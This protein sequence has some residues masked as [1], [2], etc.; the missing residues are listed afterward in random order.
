MSAENYYRQ[1]RHQKKMMMMLYFS[2]LSFTLLFFTL[3]G[4]HHRW[5]STGYE[6]PSCILLSVCSRSA[7]GLITFFLQFA[8]VLL[9]FFLHFASAFPSHRMYH[10]MMQR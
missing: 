10:P 5:I 2:F 4:Q 8:H 6:P 1:Q 3:L 7:F 9:Q